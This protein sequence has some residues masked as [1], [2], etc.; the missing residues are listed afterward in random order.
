MK[1]I[2]AALI[3]FFVFIG[4]SFGKSNNMHSVLSTSM[5]MASFSITENASVLVTS[6]SEV[7]EPAE[8]VA[9]SISLI[10][11]NVVYEFMNYP[12]KSY[13]LRECQILKNSERV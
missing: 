10:A 8:A 5:G 12:K 6:G 13:F 3:V 2:N 11:L 9:S 7:N 1:F 4:N